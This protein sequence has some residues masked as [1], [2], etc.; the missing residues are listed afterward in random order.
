MSDINAGLYV[1]RAS[2]PATFTKVGR[3]DVKVKL[4][5]AGIGSDP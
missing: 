1:L 5:G 2:V 4:T 3:Y